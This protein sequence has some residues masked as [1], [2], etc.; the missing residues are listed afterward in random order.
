MKI[1]TRLLAGFSIVIVVSAALGFFAMMIIGRTS[2]MT[3]ELYDRPMM[4]SDFARSA[5][6]D[7]LRLDRA[8]TLAAMSA[9]G[10]MLKSAAA[11][12]AGLE[13]TVLEDLGIVQERFPGVSGPVLVGDVK[14]A[15]AD[16][17][18]STKRILVVATPAELAP[19]LGEKDAVAGKV[20][21]K[22]DILVEGAKEEGLTFRQNAAEVGAFSYWILLVGLGV[23]VTIG[24][25][26]A[27]LIA[28]SIARPITAIT[29][30]MTELASGQTSV[31]I[32]A[33]GRTDEVGQM[34]KAVEVF[35][36]NAIDGERFQAERR[37]EQMRKEDRHRA[38][39]AHIGTFDN[40]VRVALDDLATSATAMHAT[41]Q[42]MSSTAEESSRQ[43]TAVAAAAEQASVNVQTVANATDEL[44][45]SVAEIGRQVVNSTTIAG[46][47]VT[48]ARR[49][50]QTV[51]GLSAAARKI[52]DVVKLISDIASQ[53]NLL[54]L[55]ATIEAARAGDAG[56]GFAV[57]ASE[58][59]NLA[60]QTAKATEEISAQIASMQG[61][62]EEAVRAIEGISG[63]IS[64]INEIATTIASAVEEQG[65]ATQ[66]IARNVQEA[67]KGTTEVSSNITGV[68]EAAGETGVAAEEVFTS[69]EDLSKQARI[70]RTE[71]DQFLA[72]IRAA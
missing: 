23:T 10:E 41:S 22:L 38:V 14:A 3:G 45:S 71:I 64:S 68:N 63:T 33:L 17:S 2:A 1:R 49:T 39:E 4:A 46:Q 21:E 11:P 40:L 55:N 53:T 13:A 37:E 8:V 35:K 54:A 67:A 51:Q 26:I 47:A 44:S 61:A 7:F 65:A 59:K 72:N 42:R 30:T 60:N 19:L 20:E 29:G 32:P 5:V 24:I 36:Q 50:N 31:A 52:G 28:R 57:V 48:E 58:V 56:K 69:A 15:L 34:A 43:A 18:R 25:G 16:W 12:I 6:A 9:S 70:L 27:L 62:T 66:E